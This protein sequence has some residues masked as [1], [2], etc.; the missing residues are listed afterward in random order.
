MARY[1]AE[2]GEWMLPHVAN[3]PLTSGARSRRREAKCL[4]QPPPRHGASPGDLKT[5]DRPALLQRQVLYLESKRGI[6]SAVQNGAWSSTPGV[7]LPTES[8]RIESTMDLDPAP[9]VGWAQLVDATRLMRTLLEKAGLNASQDHRRQGAHVVAPIEPRLE[10]DKVKEVHPARGEFRSRR[11]EAL[12]RKIS[13]S[14][15]TGKGSSTTCVTP[16]PPARPRPIPRERG[17]KRRVDALEWSDSA[18]RTSA[19]F[20]VKTV[21]KRLR[22]S[23]LTRG[24]IIVDPA[25]DHRDYGAR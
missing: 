15:R 5:F 10:W 7:L 23:R 18:A 1:Y 21:P 13:K 22:S 25:G 2:V 19:E 12:H 17:R 11:S 3:R 9:D 24:P 16:R 14:Q 6:L 4:Y 20:T 8:N